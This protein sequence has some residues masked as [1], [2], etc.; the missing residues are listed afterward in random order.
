MRDELWRRACKKLDPKGRVLQIWSARNEQGFEYR[1]H[2]DTDHWLLDY[3]GLA[4]VTRLRRPPRKKSSLRKKW[5]KKKKA[6]ITQISRH[7]GEKRQSPRTVDRLGLLTKSL[8][9]IDVG[10]IC[11]NIEHFAGNSRAFPTHVGVNRLSP[12]TTGD[13]HELS[14]RMW[15]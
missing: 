6:M 12:H 2:G 14:P 7:R 13:N 9:K 1:Q 11:C 4:L 5:P 3:E 8:A 15:G 10:T